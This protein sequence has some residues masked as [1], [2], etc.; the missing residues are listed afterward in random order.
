[1]LGF[2]IFVA[3]AVAAAAVSGAVVG[4]Y[5]AVTLLVDAVSK[6]RW[7]PT[8]AGVAR[9]VFFAGLL[10]LFGCIS[11]ETAR[12]LDGGADFVDSASKLVTG[13][14]PAVGLGIHAGCMLFRIVVGLITKKEGGNGPVPVAG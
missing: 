6:I 3:K 8:L 10:L 11:E 5:L 12:K 14:Q 4:C 1:M 13:V 2:L 9:F 7:R